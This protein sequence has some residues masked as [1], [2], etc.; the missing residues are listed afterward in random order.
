[1]ET[2]QTATQVPVLQN[3]VTLPEVSFSQFR[4][5][6]KQE[7]GSMSE[8]FSFVRAYDPKVTA[9]QGYRNAVLRYRN[10]DGKTTKAAQM[11]TVPQL[12]LPDDYLMVLSEKAIR[13]F[14]QVLED[15]E[16][17]IIRSQVEE[18]TKASNIKWVELG[19][20]KALDFLTA[21]RVSQRLTREQIEAWFLIAGKSWCEARAEE[22]CTGKNI[23]DAVEVAKQKAGTLNAYKE[24]MMKLAAPVPN[25]GQGQ[26]TALKNMLVSSKLDDDMA[27]VL[28]AKIKQI[29]EPKIT[30]NVDL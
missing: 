26:A 13:V 29:L 19:V 18:P 17:A 14:T 23:T 15:A 7:D 16:D 20:D 28:L 4:A 11:V 24:L 30:E 5:P 1:M 21:E 12:V 27:K 3:V 2:Q 9:Q 10:T 22:I 6:E 8:G 25:I